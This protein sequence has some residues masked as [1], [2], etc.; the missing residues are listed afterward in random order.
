MP[1]DEDDYEWGL[2]DE[3]GIVDI[4]IVSQSVPLMQKDKIGE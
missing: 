2:M 3:E 1:L 4:Q